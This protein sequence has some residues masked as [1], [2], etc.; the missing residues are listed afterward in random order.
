MRPGEVTAVAGNKEVVELLERWL[1]VAKEG[2]T[3]YVALAMIK[4][5]NFMIV[6]FVGC[7]EM[8]NAINYA[9]KRVMERIAEAK[10]KRQLPP[11]DPT[12][13]ADHV[14]YDLGNYPLSYDFLDWI[15]DAEQTRVREGAP[16]PLKVAFVGADNWKKDEYRRV[17]LEGVCHPLIEM[18]GAVEESDCGGRTKEFFT[19]KFITEA[20]RRGEPVPRFTPPQGAMITVEGW[21]EGGPPPVTITLREAEHIPHRNSNMVAWLRFGQTLEKRGERVIFVRD[22]C[23]AEEPLPDYETCPMASVNLHIRQAL[24]EQAKLNMFVPNGPWGMALFGTRPWLMFQYC[25][26]AD[27]Y[28]PNHPAWWH[29]FQGIMHGEQFPWCTSQQRIV[30]KND[31]YENLI[32][33]WAEFEAQNGKG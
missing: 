20:A 5:P 4:A 33:A 1:A 7:T 9:L 12:L 25:D 32:E 31:D 11:R 27:I 17:M 21:L 26:P 30:W 24:Y 23:K 6:D 19:T 29:D 16:A 13:T 15:I 10:A 8:E 28:L 18:I 22:T 3:N 2:Q 14:T